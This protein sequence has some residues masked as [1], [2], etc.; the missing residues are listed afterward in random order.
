M[1]DDNL[2]PLLAQILSDNDPINIAADGFIYPGSPGK[3]IQDACLE[4]VHKTAIWIRRI[5]KTEEGFLGSITTCDYLY[6]Q[7]IQVDVL[8]KLSEVAA[9]DLADKVE[10]A[11]KA[12]ST[13]SYA[14]SSRK[15]D[16]QL[17]S[18]MPLWDD[19]LSCWV[20]MIRFRAKGAYVSA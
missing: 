16:L 19:K 8:S 3:T 11:L 20:E 1:A 18:R 14:G 9:F 12:V 10:A 6:D 5:S 2:A 15:T 7:L 17:H 4:G 13:K